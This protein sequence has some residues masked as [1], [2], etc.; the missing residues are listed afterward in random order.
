M[1]TCHINT[2]LET[3]ETGEFIF[4]KHIIYE[5]TCA[6]KRDLNSSLQEL[7]MRLVYFE[8]DNGNLSFPTVLVDGITFAIKIAA[9]RW[10][11][12]LKSH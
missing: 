11:N 8:N 7:Q 4:N 6:P 9:I 12:L 3:L 2:W 10:P 1:I 5:Q